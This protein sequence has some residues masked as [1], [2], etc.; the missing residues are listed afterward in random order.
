MYIY[1]CIHT[2]IYTHI[3]IYIYIYIYICIHMYVYIYICIYIY[4]YIHMSCVSAA[5][6]FRQSALTAVFYQP[7]PQHKCNTRQYDNSNNNSSGG[8]CANSIYCYYCIM[9]YCTVSYCLVSCCLAERF[10]QLRPA[11]AGSGRLRT[12]YTYN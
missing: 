1:I 6:T 7:A 3:H 4:I 10:L 8:I 9:L 11:P 12:A 2:H 5:V